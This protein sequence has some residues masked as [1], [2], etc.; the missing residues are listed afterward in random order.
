[1]I[2]QNRII[3]G[4]IIEFGDILEE[5]RLIIQYE[6]TLRNMVRFW[7]K[8]GLA[9]HQPAL[10]FPMKRISEIGKLDETLSY[11]MDY[12]LLC[13]LLQTCSVDY[14]EHALARF[15]LHETTKTCSKQ[16]SFRKEMCRIS[17]RYWHLIPDLD[18]LSAYLHAINLMVTTAI[19]EL[20]KANF[21]ESF[22]LFRESFRMK[23]YLTVGAVFK[24]MFRLA[25]GGRLTGRTLT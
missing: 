23:P 10:F 19:H 21:Q 5:E 6:I 12:D 4:Q 24:E 16:A 18:P 22:D 2:K 7:D 20:R 17:H 9:W 15:R 8:G 11:L 25:V 13:R 3:A 1:M 14:L